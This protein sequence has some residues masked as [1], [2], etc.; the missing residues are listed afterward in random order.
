MALD[1]TVADA[2]LF[3]RL[4]VAGVYTPAGG[5]P[6]DLVVIL[7]QVDSDVG[8]P[9]VGVRAPE[10][11]V[12]V[13]V[14]ELAAPARGATLVVAGETLTLGTPERDETGAVWRIGCRS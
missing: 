10:R 6:V 4:G 14:A 2:V 8:V 9:G 5:D 13:R 7:D 1:F 12:R 11:F 3:S